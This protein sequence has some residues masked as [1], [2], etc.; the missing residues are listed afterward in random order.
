MSLI[1]QTGAVCAVAINL[2]MKNMIHFVEFKTPSMMKQIP[3][4]TCYFHINLIPSKYDNFTHFRILFWKTLN[5][6]GLNTSALVF[7]SF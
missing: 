7:I 1:K 3:I 6:T 5:R 4:K 2:N